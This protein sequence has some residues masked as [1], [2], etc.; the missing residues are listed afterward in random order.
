VVC[1]T[2]L[3]AS[4]RG[5][6]RI[7]LSRTEETGGEEEKKHLSKVV[8]PDFVATVSPADEV[9]SCVSSFFHFASE[10]EVHEAGG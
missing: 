8:C 4:E 10:F 5:N 7:K 3:R 2:F 9:T 6:E 1:Y